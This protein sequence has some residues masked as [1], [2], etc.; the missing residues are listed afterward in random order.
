MPNPVQYKAS[1]PTPSAVK[2]TNCY[3]GTTSSGGAYGPTSGT[4]FYSGLTPPA[5]GYVV[6]QNKVSD[7][8][9]NKVIANDADMI[10]F[11]KNKGYQVLEDRQLPMAFQTASFT[12]D[13]CVINKDLE[14]IIADD[15]RFHID[16]GFTPS[17]VSSSQLVYS[18]GAYSPIISGTLEPD[19]TSGSRYSAD[20]G[21]YIRFVN[22][23]YIETNWTAA[24]VFTQ[25]FNLSFWT[26]LSGSQSSGTRLFSKRS[27]SSNGFEI[28]IDGNKVKLSFLGTQTL[29][30]TAAG[31]LNTDDWNY[32]SIN[33]GSTAAKVSL[34][35]GSERSVNY[36]FGTGLSNITS[37]Q[38]VLLGT[39]DGSGNF[40]QGGIGVT[41]M[42]T[43]ELSSD[44]ID[45]N[46]GALKTRFG[47]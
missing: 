23:E 36:S 43:E 34:N 20:N 46:Y 5:G 25:P 8:P 19:T 40:L 38:P 21:G 24:N 18:L 12:D 45:T 37:T 4:G 26:Y 29:D 41:S 31:N 13:I 27:T 10:A 11:F 14:P 35:N 28:Y 44:Q 30:F 39:S 42:Y 17:Y 9:S 2:A 3:I 7:G 33:F 16:G 22:S 1:S 15:L 6:Y 47:L 32:I